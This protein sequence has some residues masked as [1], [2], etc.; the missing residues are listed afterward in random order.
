MLKTHLN[1]TFC[2]RR[3][4]SQKYLK[5]IQKTIVGTV[6]FRP[7]K[8][9]RRAKALTNLENRTS[10]IPVYIRLDGATMILA[11]GPVFT[12]SDQQRL[13]TDRW[14]G[15]IAMKSRLG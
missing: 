15:L 4:I 10:S 8:Q 12:E 9:G 11:R 14:C 2:T 7:H 5:K 6:G 13:E 3:K 1:F